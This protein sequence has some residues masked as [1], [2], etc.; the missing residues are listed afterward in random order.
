MFSSLE[1]ESESE[2]FREHR[3]NRGSCKDASFFFV[4]FF[5]VNMTIRK[6]TDQGVYFMNERRQNSLEHEDCSGC[7]RL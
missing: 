5:F 7:E 1:T 2:M 3:P 4:L 6:Q